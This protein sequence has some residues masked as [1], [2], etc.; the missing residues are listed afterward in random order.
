MINAGSFAVMNTRTPSLL[1]AFYYLLRCDIRLQFVTLDTEAQWIDCN[2]KDCQRKCP[3]KSSLKIHMRTHTGGLPKFTKL[4]ILHI[5][6]IVLLTGEKPYACEFK[7]CEKSFPQK[8]HLTTHMRIHT[9][10]PSKPHGSSP[11]FPL[12]A[13]A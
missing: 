10:D 1:T 8:I 9:G 11:L 6:F 3:S 7:D 12:R 5:T 2:W 4:M 13:R